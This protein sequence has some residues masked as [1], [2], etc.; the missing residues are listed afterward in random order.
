MPPDHGA[1]IVNEILGS[2]ALTASWKSELNA[3]RTRINTLRRET[4]EQLAKTCPQR[5]FGFI[6][7]QKG[8][9]SFLG[10]NVEQVTKLRTQHHVY[11]TD[12]SRI[13]IAGLRT[14]NIPHFARAVAQVLS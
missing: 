10:V 3:M 14:D 2:E 13:N 11:M 4:V 6:A 9:F 1:A 5:D 8:M 12:D 7:R